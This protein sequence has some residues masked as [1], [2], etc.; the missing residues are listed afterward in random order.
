[1]RP[2]QSLTELR[3]RRDRGAQHRSSR[4]NHLVGEQGGSEA[5]RRKLGGEEGH[6]Q[7]GAGRTTGHSMEGLLSRV[8]LQFLFQ[9]GLCENDRNGRGTTPLGFQCNR[10]S[11]SVYEPAGQRKTDMWQPCLAATSE[12]QLCP[13]N[14]W[15]PPIH[16]QQGR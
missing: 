13:K 3:G 16:F 4:C 7:Q 12:H 1:M 15:K 2:G 11:S 9:R 5:A 8:T 10:R 14:S 6:G